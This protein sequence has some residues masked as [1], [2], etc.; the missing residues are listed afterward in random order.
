MQDMK[1]L[2]WNFILV[3][4]RTV[5]SVSQWF[6]SLVSTHA[7]AIL[8]TFTEASDPDSGRNDGLADWRGG[9]GGDTVVASFAEATQRVWQLSISSTVN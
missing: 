4:A 9:H 3:P 5:D 6:L 7:P 2:E 1:S 8:I